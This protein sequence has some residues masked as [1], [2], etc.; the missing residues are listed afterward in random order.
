MELNFKDDWWHGNLKVEENK[1]A[2]KHDGNNIS[3]QIDFRKSRHYI[4][5]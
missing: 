5:K 4:K 1:I 2:A 3:V